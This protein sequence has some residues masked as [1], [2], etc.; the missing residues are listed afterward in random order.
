M[1][2]PFIPRNLNDLRGVLVLIPKLRNFV[3]LT[4][5]VALLIAFGVVV[6]AGG[7]RRRSSVIDIIIVSHL[8]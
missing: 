1:K 8:E 5:F 2:V 4:A 6:L 7:D 3:G